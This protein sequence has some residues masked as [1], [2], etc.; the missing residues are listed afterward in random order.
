MSNTNLPLSQI[1]YEIRR[2]VNSPSLDDCIREN[3]RK[4]IQR[5][6]TSNRPIGSYK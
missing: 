3:R 2:K 4:A 6:M 5:L 1:Q